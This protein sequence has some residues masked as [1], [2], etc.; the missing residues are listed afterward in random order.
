MV[1]FYEFNV[2]PFN[3]TFSLTLSAPAQL[4]E[5]CETSPRQHNELGLI[6]NEET[7][8]ARHNNAEEKSFSMSSDDLRIP[9]IIK[10]TIKNIT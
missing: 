8:L 2:P 3:L 6:H 9:N 10:Q 4:I 1:L 7:P 5:A